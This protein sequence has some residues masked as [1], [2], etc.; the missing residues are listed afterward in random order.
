MLAK[1]DIQV[2]LLTSLTALKMSKKIL[3][4][5]LSAL[6]LAGCFGGEEET[7]ESIEAR[8]PTDIA[9]EYEKG[10]FECQTNADCAGSEWCYAT[11]EFA[12][13]TQK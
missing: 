6:L 13:C 1:I 3:T 10:I 12:A 2:R 8:I 7:A 5:T 9:E 4:I 11:E